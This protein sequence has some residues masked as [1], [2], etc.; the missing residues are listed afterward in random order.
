[1]NVGWAE[2][3]LDYIKR[4]PKAVVQPSVEDIDQNT[5]HYENRD[6]TNNDMWRGAFLWDLR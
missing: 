3:V 6:I 5:I 1:M 2:P 4:N